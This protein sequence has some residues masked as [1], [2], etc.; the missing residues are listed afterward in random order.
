[1]RAPALRREPSLGKLAKFEGVRAIFHA[2]PEA[3]ATNISSPPSRPYPHE[4]D[5]AARKIKRLPRSLALAMLNRRF[6]IL[7]KKENAPFVS[8]GVRSVGT[9]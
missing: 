3:P 9:I 8:G 5:T 2:E 4:A 6:S 1:M 7:A